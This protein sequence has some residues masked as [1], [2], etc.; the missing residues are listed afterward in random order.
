[1]STTESTTASETVLTSVNPATGETIATHPIADADAVAAAVATARTAAATWGALSYA[2]R[3]RHL[4][5]WSSR[6]VAV[7]DELCDLIHAEN[8]KT[9]DDAF[10]ELM[11]VLEHIAWAAKNA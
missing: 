6:L 2:E 5:R 10:L 7:S 3:K 11:L 8:G 4:L 1:M 9:R